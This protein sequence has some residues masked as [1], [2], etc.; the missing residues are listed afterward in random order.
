MAVA[1]PE[2]V[3]LTAF[4]AVML[5]IGL[6]IATAWTFERLA[7]A[8]DVSILGVH[9]FAGIAGAIRHYVVAG[10]N[11]G[12]ASLEHVARD[13]WHWSDWALGEMIAGVKAFAHSV[14]TSITWL[15]RHHVFQVASALVNPVAAVA[16]AAKTAA[17]E[18]KR[19]VNA[20]ETSITRAYERADGAVLQT[21]RRDMA[22]LKGT[23]L[24][25][26]LHAFTVL[27]RDVDAAI[28]SAFQQAETAASGAISQA[29]T[30]ATGAAAAAQAAGLA[31]VDRL[32]VAED[33]AIGAARQAE[34]ATA[35]ELR[36]LLARVNAGDIA[37]LIAAVPLLKAAIDTL[38]A[39]TGLGRAECR[40]KVKGIC[41]VDPGR[42]LHL[43]EGLAFAFAWPGL[44]EFADGL[45]EIV[46]EVTEAI[47]AF[48]GID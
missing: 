20:L 34:T 15:Q 8:L 48:V 47:T 13:L 16:E 27:E 6:L 24:A 19:A 22:G 9:P 39:E 40:A 42:W 38:E 4:A 29:E 18:A 37:A 17:A 41:G 7:D 26:P 5:L 33:A 45:A 46:P 31:A 12:I 43:L 36:D 32:R 44:E 3:D 28:A 10:V 1:L 11:S 14:D 25:E 30:R 21:A 2:L 35:G 23:L